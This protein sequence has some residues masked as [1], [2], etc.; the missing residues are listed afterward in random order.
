MLKY[1]RMMILLSLLSILGCKGV[2]PSDVAGTW[3]IK[4]SSRNLLPPELQRATATIVLDANGT[5]IA[6]EIPEELPPAPPYDVKDRKFR[7]NTG[8]GDWKLVSSE[9]KQQVQLNFRTLQGNIN[10]PFGTQMEVST[11]W[12]SPNLYYFL[13]DADEGRRISLV[14]K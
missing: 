10:V 8:S 11:G 1:S 9:G 2:Q 4:D 14:K 12:S 6:S 7:M 3:V 13:G 5:F